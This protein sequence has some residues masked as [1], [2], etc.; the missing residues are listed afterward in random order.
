MKKNFIYI[1]ILLISLTFNI[2]KAQE[3][4]EISPLFEYPVA[5]EDI[6]SLEAKCDYLVKNFWD[7]FDFKKKQPVDQ[8]A[9]NEAFDVYVTPMR[10]ASKSAVDQSV[11]KL[12]S[13]ISGNPVLLLQFTKA[14]EENLYGPRAE[15]WSDDLY[16]KFLEALIKN[17]KVSEQRKSKY[18]KQFNEIKSSSQDNIAPSFD[19]VDINGNLKHY[20]P[21][22]TPTILIFG[23]PEDTD[24]RLS[25]LKMDSNFS[26]GEALE[27]GKLNILYIVTSKSD[28]WQ[29]NLSSYNKRW[30]VGKLDSLSDK[31]DT[32]L[33][34][35]VYLIG[36]DGK[37]IKKFSPLEEAVNMALDLVK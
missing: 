26:L 8:F 18:I 17:K 15:F 12:V 23:D 3:V 25:R 13:K 28:N 29:N 24:W 14:A 6:E 33:N 2:V 1:S 35:S 27:K 5:P 11:D 31:Y 34:P 7:N 36:S 22:S 19:F 32:R 30:T 21:M 10:Y 4:I 20:F 9:L 16:L 37:I